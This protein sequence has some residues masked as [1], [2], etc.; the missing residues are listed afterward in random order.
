MVRTG[1]FEM[2]ILVRGLPLA[3]TRIGGCEFVQASDGVAFEVRLVNSNRDATYMVRLFV[4]G[5]EAEPGFVKKIRNETTF[6]GFV[7]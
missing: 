2:Q 3:E 5:T 7:G 1:G 6:R 4:D